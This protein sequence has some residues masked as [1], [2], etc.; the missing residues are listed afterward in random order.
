M[1]LARFVRNISGSTLTFRSVQLADQA[2]QEIPFFL[3][4]ELA[5]DEDLVTAINN[6]ELV[7]SFDGITPLSKANSLLALQTFA[8]SQQIYFDK[9]SSNFANSIL[10][11]RD[12]LINLRE[13]LDSGV[14]GLFEATKLVAG[15]I[16]STLSTIIWDNEKKNN[17]TGLFSLDTGTGV[18]TFNR[19]AEIFVLS[20][21]TA[22]VDSNSRSGSRSF[23]Q[24]NSGGGFSNVNGSK[25]S[26]Y[27][28]QNSTGEGS[29]VSTCTI[30]VQA[31]NQLRIVAEMYSGDS[32]I[33]LDLDGCSLIIKESEARGPRGLQGNSAF[34]FLFG[35]GVPAN[36][37]GDDGDLYVDNLTGDLYRKSGGTWTLETNIKGPTGNLVRYMIWAEESGGLFNN[38]TQWSFGNGATGNIG[39]PMITAGRLIGMSLNA[40]N[41]PNSNCTV[42]VLINGVSSGVSI[43]VSAGV[44]DDFVV[45]G[46]PVAYSAGD[47]IG[48]R[49]VLG[50]GASDVR[51]A[52]LVEEV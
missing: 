26:S 3:Y 28:R 52:T 31:G 12:A 15:N 10:N 39:I 50:G 22:D 40:E 46:S 42:E 45:F 36:G 34:Q 23:V 24:F 44:N 19:E 43:T 18:V 48:F 20:K 13:D 35:D 8:E 14:S 27:H 5:S 2:F 29:L 16:T 1:A 41:A 11:V 30:N 47:R 7:L 33:P 17:D 6:D 25:G 21:L 4:A 37:L 32:S 38:A 51:V 49:T 9:G